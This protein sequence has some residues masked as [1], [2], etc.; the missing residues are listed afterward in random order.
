MAF[1]ESTAMNLLNPL[2][3]L[4]NSF[5]LVVPKLIF[6]IIILMI[7]Y[8]LALIIG[9]AVK[10]IVHRIGVEKGIA[11]L[12]LP[13]AIGKVKVASVLGQITKWYIFIIFIQA[14][15]ETV[16]LGMLSIL[17]T[18]FSLWLPQLIIAVLAVMLGL[19]LSHYLSH[20]LETESQMKG[21][22]L[23]SGMF[24]VMIMFIAIVIALEQIGVEVDILHNTFLIVLGSI[25]FGFALATG[26]AF[27]LGMK[28]RASGLYDSIRK[29]F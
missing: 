19:F 29:N 12:K 17:L 23:I 3:N 11:K 22:K 27:G 25:G 6:A 1:I 10:I 7:G 5:V 15:A 26:L 2:V 9:H 21:I 14:A 28:D 13:A 20:L 18:K 4:W 8:L 16:N 24:K